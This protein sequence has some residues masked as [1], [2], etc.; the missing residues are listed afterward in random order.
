MKLWICRVM[1][2]VKDILYKCRLH[3]FRML[4]LSRVF[5]KNEAPDAQ[6]DDFR[7]DICKKRIYFWASGPCAALRSLR[8]T[9]RGIVARGAF[10]SRTLAHPCAAYVKPC[11]GPCAVF[12]YVAKGKTLRVFVCFIFSVEYS[13]YIYIYILFVFLFL[14][15]VTLG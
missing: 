10:L 6:N 13:I 9:L 14:V 12:C 15:G 8:N 7:K 3:T 2:F 5:F 1:I 11:A 4:I